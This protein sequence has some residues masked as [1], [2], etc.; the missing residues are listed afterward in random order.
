MLGPNSRDAIDCAAMKTAK[1][2]D[3][4]LRVRVLEK[5]GLGAQPELDLDGLSSLYRRWCESVPFDNAAKLIALRTNASGNFPGIE[6]SQFFENFVKHGYGGTCWPS[7]NALYSLL[8]DLDFDARRLAGSMRD[9]GMISH[10]STKVR[11]DGTDWLV[12]SSMLTANPL[13]LRDELFIATDPLWAAEVEH[14]DGT[15]IIWWDAVPAPEY[16]PCRLLIDDATHDFYVE[17]YEASRAR[18]PFNER[19]YVRRNARNSVLVITGNRRFVKTSAG[20][21]ASL[22]SERELVEHL[23][24]EAGFS[25]KVIDKLRDCGA[26]AA[27]MIPPDEPPPPPGGVRPSKR[28]YRR[29]PTPGL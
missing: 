22:L 29:S 19:I 11:V 13:P 9:T 8:F 14:V 7:S 6:A 1:L 17:R 15:H 5:L 28:A 27:S 12:D 21:D 26:I 3:E 4:R 23:A 25:L 10:G 2:L 24:D 18:S 16:I 20:V